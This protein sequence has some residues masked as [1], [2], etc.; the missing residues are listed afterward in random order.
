MKALPIPLITLVDEAPVPEAV[1]AGLIPALRE[2]YGGELA[3][4]A[5][6]SP[7]RPL[8]F[9]NFVTTLDGVVAFNLPGKDTGNAI[10]GNSVIDHVV[11]GILR[12]QADAVIWGAR[13]Y[14]S[15]HRFTPTPA[16]IWP[17]GAD[18]FA[19]QRAHLGKQPV[20]LAV[21]ITGSGE[22]DTSGAIFQR[23]EQ[24]ALV[25]T[26]DE[27]MRR[28]RDLAHA[29]ATDVRSVGPGPHVA[30]IR[31][32]HLLRQEFDVRAALHEG[33]AALFGAFLQAGQMDEVFLTIAPQFA[34]RSS[35]AP[36]PGLVE[37]VAFV[38]ATAPWGALLSLKR[39]GSHLF[40]RY[41]ITGER[42]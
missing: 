5:P 13:T 18:L 24:P 29:P 12:C 31:A 39:G 4:P 19:A 17:P 34:G 23:A 6:T 26:T 22:I 9:A 41:A 1:P 42:R 16:A 32:A 25:I 15:A 38:P 33:G 21:V 35:A 10:S 14:Q 7:D 36:R 30:P 28:L 40:T 2:L 20:P 37:E 11:M 3:L 8:F 27:G